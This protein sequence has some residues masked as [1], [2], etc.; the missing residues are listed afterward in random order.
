M[1]VCV[2]VVVW[3][4]RWAAAWEGD[5]WCVCVGGWFGRWCGLSK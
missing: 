5:D 1:C 4:G 3:V 2:V